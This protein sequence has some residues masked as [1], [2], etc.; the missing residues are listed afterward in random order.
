MPVPPPRRRRARAPH[1][2]AAR[3]VGL[4][5]GV[6]LAASGSLAGCADSG[7]PGR[8]TA[9][10]EAAV[11]PEPLLTA[12]PGANSAVGALPAGFPSALLPA[13]PDATILVASAVPGTGDPALTTVSLNLTTA[14]TG[15]ELVDLY[16]RSLTAAGFVE[17][18]GP[19]DAALAAGATFTRGAGGDGAELVVVGV[20]DR[21][22]IRTLTLGGQVRSGS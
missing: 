4:L 7:D 15:P 5:A 1:A 22:G 16:R 9:Q 14:M 3:A 2:R 18:S 10:P 13:P 8:D 17:G 19:S 20:L 11:S 12:S 21:D 6:V